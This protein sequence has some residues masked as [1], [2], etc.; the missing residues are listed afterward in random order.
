MV[1]T[2]VPCLEIG[3]TVVSDGIKVKIDTENRSFMSSNCGCTDAPHQV[4]SFTGDILNWDEVERL[5][6]GLAKGKRWTLQG[7]HL[8]QVW[9]CEA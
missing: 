2:N 8:A 1:W 7:N 4:R 9:R 3:D 6:R 5:V